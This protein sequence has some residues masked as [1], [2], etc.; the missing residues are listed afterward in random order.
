[1]VRLKVVQIVILLM[2]LVIASHV[3]QMAQAKDSHPQ[4]TSTQIKELTPENLEMFV[5]EFIPPEMD[6][7][8]VPGLVITVVR[9]DEVILAKGYGYADLENQV[10]MSPQTNIRAGSVSKSILATGVIKLVEQDVLDLD[11]PV[12]KYISDLDLED[13]FGTASTIGQ[14]LTHTSGYQDNLVLSHSAVLD[15]D[16]SLGEVLRADLPPRVFAPGSVS[17]YS[18]WNFSL[19]GYAIEGATGQPYETVLDEILF[20]PVGM[21][22]TT[23]Q[24][25]LPSEI[26][27]NLATG[28]GWNYS[29]NR[30]DIVPH[31][32]VRMSPGI[33]LVTNGEDMG[34]Y[35]RMLLNGGR[36]FTDDALSLLLER[37]GAAHE[38]SRGWSYG[39]VENT[40]A[41][42]R[43]LY[44]DG[45]GIGFASRVV[46]IPDLGLGIFVSTNHR[47]LGE[48]LWPTQ[49][50]MMA[51]RTLVSAIIENFVPESK[52]KT[53]EVQPRLENTNTARFV[54]HYQKAGISRN[55]FFKMEGLLD[56]VDV[57]D[58]GDG[59]LKI[60]SGIYQE[61]EPLVFQ[62]L[63]NPGF[64]IIFVENQSGKVEFLTFG[65]TG[66]YQKVPWYQAKNFQIALLAVITIVSLAMLI[67]WP[68]TRQG[69]WMGW[70]VSLL[71]VGFIVGVTLMFVPSVTD[72]LLFFKTIPLGVRILFA[73][74]WIIG[75]L[76]LSL[77]IFLVSAWKD[78]DISWFG[79]IHYTLMTASS[80]A[81]VW[82]ANF[83]NLIH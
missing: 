75:I 23:Y 5:D 3:A 37:Q 41:G 70:G 71:N 36:F 4:T 31:D 83:W 39:F 14:L 78:G 81:L 64:H 30:F 65:G 38:Y 80:F 9:G 69:H 18:D 35:L 27:E 2:M 73:I 20:T 62:S 76:A 19:L 58:Y 79:K 25:P 33:A 51:T 28:Y 32:Y 66:S 42:R 22:N 74:P 45:N 24:Q 17:A 50:A 59:T 47:N 11:A 13:E 68:I 8:H 29:K 15:S 6:T 44:K 26:F 49:A 34:A 40:F 53:Y 55:D 61:V 52:V 7:A 60:G 12:S 77:P 43:V 16:E 46:L 56:N 1:M 63:E 67:I 48:G 57:K 21:E 82:M 10:L 72:M 54:G